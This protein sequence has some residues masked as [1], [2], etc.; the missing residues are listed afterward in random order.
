MSSWT[1]EMHRST[2]VE[3]AFLVGRVTR[4]AKLGNNDP[5]IGTYTV[6]PRDHSKIM[7]AM[8]IECVLIVQQLGPPYALP[9][10]RS[11][12]HTQAPGSARCAMHEQFERSI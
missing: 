8:G 7:H 3:A 2:G 4:L 9:K 12:T 6:M 1:A 11:N 5:D 10:P